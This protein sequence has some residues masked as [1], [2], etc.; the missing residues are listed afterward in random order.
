MGKNLKDLEIANFL[1]T[2]EN[3]VLMCV[4]ALRMKANRTIMELIT[5]GVEVINVNNF[6]TLDVG[7][8]FCEWFIVVDDLKVM[9]GLGDAVYT[10][11]DVS[12]IDHFT[13]IWIHSHGNSNK[14]LLYS[15]AEA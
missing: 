2:A 9:W 8:L 5:E 14:S 3:Q 7:D 1:A 11:E 6:P 4:T 10:S 13:K 15:G 12:D